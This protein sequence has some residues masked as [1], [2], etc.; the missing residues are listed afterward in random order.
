MGYRLY[1]AKTYKIEWK[2]GFFNHKVEGVGKLLR[3]L[4][5]QSY[6][7]EIVP[8]CDGS[9]RMEVDKTELKEAIIKL[10]KKK[11]KLLDWMEKDGY[12]WDDV[13]DFFQIALKNAEPDE[14]YIHFEWF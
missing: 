3:K 5:P 2:G 9:D 12:T 8:E 14:D 6:H 13:I 10:M 4:C 11:P 7:E 1:Y